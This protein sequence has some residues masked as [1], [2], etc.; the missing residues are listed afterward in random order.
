MARINDNH[1]VGRVMAKILM[2]IGFIVAVLWY[3]AWLLVFS[4]ER[5]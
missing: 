3:V 4:R 2:V 1:L 5:H